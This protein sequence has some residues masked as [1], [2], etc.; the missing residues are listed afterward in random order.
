MVAQLSNRHPLHFAELLKLAIDGNG[1][2]TGAMPENEILAPHKAAVRKSKVR[3]AIFV[4]AIAAG[5]G[6]LTWAMHRRR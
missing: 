4:G 1:L 6:A 5:A 2:R 3:A